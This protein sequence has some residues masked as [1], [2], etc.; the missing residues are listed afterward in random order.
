[1]NMLEIKFIRQN[2]TEVKQAMANRGD[3]LDLDALIGADDNRK[4]MLLEIEALRHQRNVVSDQIAK[5]KKDGE[6]AAAA[7]AGRVAA[8]F[9]ARSLLPGT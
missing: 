5:M 9:S 1:M 3:R 8:F 4:K 7:M 2:L 6:T